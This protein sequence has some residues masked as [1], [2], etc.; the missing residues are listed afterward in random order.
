[1][2]E[3]K[4]YRP[5]IVRSRKQITKAEHERRLKIIKLA[6]AFES[7]GD[8]ELDDDDIVVVSEGNYNGAYVQMWKWVDFSGTQLDKEEIQEKAL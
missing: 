8:L 7:E 3:Q 5:E 2:P 4:R 1:M 6:K